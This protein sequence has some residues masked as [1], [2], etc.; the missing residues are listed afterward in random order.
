MIR[1]A[2]QPQLPQTEGRLLL[3]TAAVQN[4]KNL[5]IYRAARLYSTP[6]STL[7][8]RL[9]GAL[10][11]A[12]SNAKKRKLLPTKEQSLVQ[13]ILDLDRRGFPP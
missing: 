8:D 3:A 9:A 2:I 6:Q 12:T 1:S 4:D 10:P 11:Q 5:R 13:W 7:R